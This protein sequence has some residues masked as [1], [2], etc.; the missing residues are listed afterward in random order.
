MSLEALRHSLFEYNFVISPRTSGLYTRGL[1]IVFYMGSRGSSIFFFESQSQRSIEVWF[2]S[3]FFEGFPEVLG[4]IP[5]EILQPLKNH[6]L[7]F[8]KLL[9]ANKR[10]FFQKFVKVFFF[11][12]FFRSMEVIFLR[13]F[14]GVSEVNRRGFF[15][16]ILKDSHRY[17]EVIFN[18]I[19]K[20]S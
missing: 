16:E 4:R 12:V 1:S 13:F 18:I 6:N 7:L 19:S 10:D 14:N 8:L 3:R 2:H 20:I 11:F 15:K 9:V 17:T 5:N